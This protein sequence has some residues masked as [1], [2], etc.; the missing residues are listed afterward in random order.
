[1]LDWLSLREKCSNTEFFLD[2]TC[3]VFGLNTD[4]KKRRIWKFFTQCLE[5]V[6]ACGHNIVLINQT[7]ISL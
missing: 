6:S 2:R 7:E 1:M 5:H 3:L 4:L